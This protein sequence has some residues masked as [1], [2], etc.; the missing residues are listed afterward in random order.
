MGSDLK[1]YRV[2][3]A[4]IR[5]K[6]LPVEHATHCVFSERYVRYYQNKSEFFAVVLYWKRVQQGR[7]QTFNGGGGGGQKGPTLINIFYLIYT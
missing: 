1:A 5:M 6:T 3:N 7:S 2:K 4:S